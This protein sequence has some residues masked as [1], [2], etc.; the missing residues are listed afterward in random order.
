MFQLAHKLV[1][2]LFLLCCLLFHSTRD[3]SLAQSTLYSEDF[4]AN[5]GKGQDGTTSD[6]TGVSNWSIDVSN[7]VFNNGLGDAFKVDGGVF[8]SKDSDGPNEANACWWY[9][10][11]INITSYSNVTISAD[12]IPAASSSSN[13]VRLYYSLDGSAYLPIGTAVDGNDPAVTRTLSGLVGTTLQIRIGYWGTFATG[14]ITHDNVLVTGISTC[15][16]TV[17]P[18]GI[19]FSNINSP[20]LTVSWTAGDG[21][22]TLVVASPSALSSNPASGNS[23]TANSVYGSGSVVGNGYVVFNGPSSTTSTLIT[24]LD[25]NT[26]YTFTVFTFNSS[27]NCYLEPGPSAT[28]TTANLPMGFYVDDNSNLG[29]VFTIGSASGNNAANGK[30]LTPWASLTYALTQVIA[31]DTIYVDAGSYSDKDLA[32]PVSGLTILGAGI[33]KTYF[34]NPGT[35]NYFI[36]INENNTTLSDFTLTDFD[37]FLCSTDLGQVIGITGATGIKVNNVLIDRASQTSSGCGYPVEVR[38]GASVLF[39]GGGA[40]CNNWDAGGVVRVSGAS[41]SATFSNYLFYGNEQIFTDGTALRV[42]D[43]SVVVR[44]SRFENNSAGAG[45]TGG[46]IYQAGGSLSVFDCLFTDNSNYIETSQAGGTIHIANGNFTI[47][48]SNVMNHIQL[49]AGESYGAGISVTSGIALIDSVLFSGNDGSLSL[50]TD[51]YNDG[52]TV[53]VRNCTF[54][55]TANQIGNNSGSMTVS[56]SGF[57]SASLVTGLSYVNNLPST[58]TPNPTVP[59]FTGVCG[60]ITILPVELTSFSGEC[61]EGLSALR[62]TTATE[63]NNAY[64]SV[65]KSIDGL[66]FENI[67]TVSGA[68][69]KTTETNYSFLDFE[70][71]PGVNYY[72]LSQTD[73]DGTLR[74]LQT[75]SVLNNC[76][77]NGL[78]EMAFIVDSETNELVLIFNL[79]KPTNLDLNVLNSLGQQLM[80]QTILIEKQ[81]KIYLQLPLSLATGVYHLS[82]FDGETR[83]NKKFFI[84]K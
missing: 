44:N 39:T 64:F 71:R 29:D 58:Y 5:S 48:R 61:T 9:S 75:I 83:V 59:Q 1:L 69:N 67:A 8:Y 25:R 74:R 23:Y 2:R 76:N 17:A 20:S 50:G 84:Y 60:S 4:S 42:D 30:K 47:K 52:G 18:S 32:T 31:G 80:G 45:Q 26:N 55:S 53:T 35:D 54:S 3:F 62:W 15:L 16:P 56:E 36:H 46:A 6:M 68:V 34:N 22:Q 78:E 10:T 51:L 21:D 43:G 66:Q 81:A 49:G 70:S 72:R 37:A 24:E 73:T 33:T 12:L 82:V 77:G 28:Q 41:T 13:F 11:V 65:E 14:S 40:T 57:P 7:G 38:S 27:G 19:A 79:N 63:H